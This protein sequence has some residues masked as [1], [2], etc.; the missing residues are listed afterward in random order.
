MADLL[1]SKPMSSSGASMNPLSMLENLKNVLKGGTAEKE[2][3]AD[4]RY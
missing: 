1:A 3:E 2:D 4:I